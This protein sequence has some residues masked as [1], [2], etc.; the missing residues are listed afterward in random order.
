LLR[1]AGVVVHREGDEL[2]GCGAALRQFEVTGIGAALLADSSSMLRQ[3]FEDGNE[4]VLFDS[5][6]DAVEKAQWL[7]NHPEER[8]RIA[9]AGQSRT[10]RD[11]TTTVRAGEL[12]DLL[13]AELA[14]GSARLGT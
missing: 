11:H 10:L 4:V 5:P 14:T 7:L 1:S 2:D 3:L 13:S 9:A 6:Q 12:A 8:E